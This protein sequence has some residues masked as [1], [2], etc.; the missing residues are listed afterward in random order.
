MTKIKFPAPGWFDRRG[1][2]NPKSFY[3]F[4]SAWVGNDELAYGSAQAMLH[5]E[6]KKWL[7][8]QSDH[9][10]HIERSAPLDYAQ[11]PF[12]LHGLRGTP[13]IVKVINQVR[14]ISA[15]FEKQGIANF[16]AGTIFSF[17]EQYIR[18]QYYSLAA[19]IVLLVAFFVVVSIALMN[20][21][22]GALIVSRPSV[23]SMTLRQS[24]FPVFFSLNNVPRQNGGEC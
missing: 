24:I 11:F 10:F 22:A 4:L 2:I 12:D 9:D 8:D 19:L 7:H 21:W 20:P 15:N 23:L 18:L 3:Y 13:E 1:I 16:P 14:G 6:P 5:P 17:W